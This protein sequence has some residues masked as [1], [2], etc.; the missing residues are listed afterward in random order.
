MQIFIKA[1]EN[2][3]PCSFVLLARGRPAV[4]SCEQRS[5]WARSRWSRRLVDG[6]HRVA[7]F[8]PHAGHR[9]RAPVRRQRAPA[10]RCRRE[11]G[12]GSLRRKQ[13]RL[14]AIRRRIEEVAG[15]AP[16]VGGIEAS[17]SAGL[18]EAR[19]DVRAG[20]SARVAGPTYHEARRCGR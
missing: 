17:T 2:D 8:A 6:P 14:Q 3:P 11:E 19:V 10:P 16:L 1:P 12:A 9:R 20:E 4:H 5:W 13:P 18:G 7:G 15:D